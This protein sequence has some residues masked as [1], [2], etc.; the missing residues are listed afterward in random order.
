MAEE[1]YLI[2]NLIILRLFKSKSCNYNNNNCRDTMSE[3][4]QDGRT[5]IR[6]RGIFMHSVKQLHVVSCLLML[7][8]DTRAVVP[9]CSCSDGLYVLSCL[10]AHAQMRFTCS[11]APLLILPL[12]TAFL[13]QKKTLKS[14]LTGPD[15]GETIQLNDYSWV[16]NKLNLNS[17]AKWIRGGLGGGGG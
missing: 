12:V 10:T 5:Y 9:H 14:L 13:F 7:R 17:L 3:N 11:R 6:P 15:S 1:S 4:I 16:T 2:Y 8:L